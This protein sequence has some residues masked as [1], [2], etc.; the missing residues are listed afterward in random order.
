MKKVLFALAIILTAGLL[1]ACE[2]P[3][4]DPSL[5]GNWSYE[6]NAGW[7]YE[8]NSDGTG[9]RGVHLEIDT[10]KWS[11]RGD[12]RLILDF[13]AGYRD[14]DWNYIIEGNRLTLTR[15][16]GARETFSYLK[17]EHNADVVGTWEWDYDDS[18]K[19]I[20][21]ADGT[22]SRGFTGEIDSFEWFN[23]D[24]RIVVN[25]GTVYEELWNYSISDDVL[26]IDSRQVAGMIYSY[27]KVQ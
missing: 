14:D 24:D 19:L 27:N 6:N 5:L 15:R 13:G 12:N 1:T 10:F 26:T 4:Q 11:T 23:A 22:G 3:Q 18:Y 7:Q 16:D 21:N 25:G 8:L 17:V 2:S 9:Q 20:Y